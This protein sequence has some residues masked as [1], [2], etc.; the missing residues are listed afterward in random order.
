[1]RSS[2]TPIQEFIVEGMSCTACAQRIE[3]GLQ[4]MQ[5][6]ERAAVHFAGRSAVV[7][8]SVA[9]ADIQRTI[10]AL[11][12]NAQPIGAGFSWAEQQRIEQQRALKRLLLAILLGVPVI[13]LGMFHHLSSNVSI[14]VIEAVLTFALLAGAGREFFIKAFKLLKMRSA[15]M[16]TLVSLGAGI[17]FIWSCALAI[18]GSDSVYFETAAAIVGFVLVGKYIEQRMSWKATSSL[19]ALFDLQPRSAHRLLKDRQSE[20]ETVDVRFVKVGDQLM[21]RVGERFSAD[22]VMTEGETEVDESLLTGESRP[23]VKRVGDS[24]SAG[25]L[26]MVGVV[27]YQVQAVGSQSRLGEIVA[28]VERTQ[29]SKAPVQRLVDRVSQVFVPVVLVL[30]ILTFLIWILFLDGNASE[31]LN[32]AISVLVVACPCALGLATPIAVAV[33]THRAAQQGLLFRDLAALESLQSVQTIVLDKTGT[34]TEGRMSVTTEQWLKGMD[35]SSVGSDLQRDDILRMVIQLEQRS[36]HPIAVGLVEAIKPHISADPTS[37]ELKEIRELAGRGMFAVWDFAGKR[38]NVHIGR[39]D[40]NLLLSL[41]SNAN[42]DFSYGDSGTWVMCEIDGVPYI[43]WCLRDS[44]RRNAAAVLS[45]FK[46]FGIHAVLASGDHLDVVTFVSQTLKIEAYA[47]QTPQMKAEL[48]G[49]FRSQGRTVAMLG[50]GVND[51]PALAAADVGIAMGSGTDAAQQTAALTLKNTSLEGVLNAITLS[52]ATFRNIRENLVWAFGYNIILMPL[53]MMGR[54]T[55][56]WAAAAM[57]FSSLF[58]VLNALRLLR[59][60]VRAQG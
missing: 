20:W 6:V 51:A 43:A 35:E 30:S 41:R 15:N 59:F 2:E 53:A 8:T 52:R 57:A 11:G 32:A 13:A 23:C 31:S 7:Q 24:V 25:S 55:P 56:M 27:Q 1:M 36:Q 14:R 44:L 3:R 34:L 4:K 49:L 26:N 39:P 10:A 5:G 60:G 45:R 50:D 58:V 12:Y 40:D 19:G 48:V 21:T 33:A 22:G 18:Q 54:L 17:S 42:L 28:F 9:S 37:N 16:D 38:R 46:D 29:L 47:E